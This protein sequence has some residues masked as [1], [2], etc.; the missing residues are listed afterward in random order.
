MA[1]VSIPEVNVKRR[2]TGKG[3]V[4]NQHVSPGQHTLRIDA[5]GYAMKEVP[6]FINANER[7]VAEVVI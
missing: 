2:S 1:A 4:Y 6:V 5:D 7:T 3:Q